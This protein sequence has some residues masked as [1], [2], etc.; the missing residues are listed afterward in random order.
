MTYFRTGMISTVNFLCTFL[1]ARYSS[2][3]TWNFYFLSLAITPN[4][5]F[6]GT[7]LT[8]ALMARK[9]AKVIETVERFKTLIGLTRV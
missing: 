4:F 9:L 2:F 6:F 8:L 5:I 1:V 7:R 3:T